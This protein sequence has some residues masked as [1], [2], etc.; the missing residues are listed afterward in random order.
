[1]M[2]PKKIPNNEEDF[3]NKE[4]YGKVEVLL[5]FFSAPVPDLRLIEVS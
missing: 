2:A 1:M 4:D 5:G 3:L